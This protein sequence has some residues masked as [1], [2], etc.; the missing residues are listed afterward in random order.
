MTRSSSKGAKKGS[1]SGGHHAAKP[2][3]CL[4]GRVSNERA[5]PGEEFRSKCRAVRAAPNTL[6]SKAAHAGRV[7]FEA[8]VRQVKFRKRRIVAWV[9]NRGWRRAWKKGSID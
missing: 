5:S 4:S 3:P 9:V 1:G 6:R 8:S 2:K 7:S